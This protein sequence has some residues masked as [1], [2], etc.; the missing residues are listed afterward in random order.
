MSIVIHLRGTRCALHALIVSER[1]PEIP[2][3]SSAS[4]EPL[5]SRPCDG[6]MPSIVVGLD[7]WVEIIQEVPEGAI[8]KAV[9]NLVQVLGTLIIKLGGD[10]SKVLSEMSN[11]MIE[12]P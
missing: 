4:A 7:E 10:E 11:F 5:K 8:L 12:P 9:I 2:Y 6:D 3:N 1:R